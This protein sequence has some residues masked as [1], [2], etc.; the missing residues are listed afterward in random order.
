MSEGLIF[1]QTKFFL[2]H[3]KNTRQS[4]ESSH[5]CFH[6]FTSYIA[7]EPCLRLRREVDGNRCWWS[8]FSA[9]ASSSHKLLETQRRLD[10]EGIDE[11][12]HQIDW[13]WWILEFQT[14]KFTQLD[15]FQMLLSSFPTLCLHSFTLETHIL[16]AG[17]LEAT[18][19]VP[20]RRHRQRRIFCCNNNVITEPKGNSKT[21]HIL[22]YVDGLKS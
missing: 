12:I 16:W 6:S 11:I 2:P 19:C 5:E 18:M 7:N 21:A 10:D 15:T 1:S 14:W 9:V 4:I 3:V 20:Q 13:W 22:W 17:I 8:L